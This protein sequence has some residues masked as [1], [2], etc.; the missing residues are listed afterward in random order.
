MDWQTR[1]RLVAG[2]FLV[3]SAVWA[4]AVVYWTSGTAAGPVVAGPAAV[5]PDQFAAS[6]AS[7]APAPAGPGQTRI[8]YRSVPPVAASDIP[9]QSLIIPVQGVKPAQLS[10]TFTQAREGGLRVHDA[11]DIMAPRGTP[12]LAAAGGVIEKFFTSAAG[13]LTLYLRCDDRR[14]IQYYAHLDAY[15]PGLAEGQHVAQGQLLGTVGSTGNA[16]PDGPHLHFAIQLTDPAANWHQPSRPINPYP[17][18]TRR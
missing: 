5:M 14:L 12:V 8:A 18:L 17:L 11:I 15:A 9:A 7:A 13:G 16:N 1:L 10:D 4:A 6:P 2:T 3:T